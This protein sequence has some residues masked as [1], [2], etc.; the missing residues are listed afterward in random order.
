VKLIVGLGNPGAKYQKTRHNVGFRLIDELADSLGLKWRDNKTLH[1]KA[2]SIKSK[3]ILIKPQAFMNNSGLVVRTVMRKQ[4]IKPADIL[5]LYD[6][7]DM[8][9]G[10]VRFRPNGSSGGHNG[11]Q[12]IIDTLRTKEIPR[13]K[14][15][16]GRSNKAPPDKY[17]LS[18][19]SAGELA[20]IKSSL[21]SAIDLVK[22]KMHL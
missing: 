6:D 3:L 2:A 17:V 10:K 11:I 19:F 8:E 4:G 16:I 18:D 20:H 14:I 12:S 13:I 15:G 1:A 7:I 21:D 5:V 22:T 9:L